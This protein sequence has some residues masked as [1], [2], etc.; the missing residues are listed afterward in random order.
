MAT[1][2]PM[3]TKDP[4]ATDSEDPKDL[5]VQKEQNV[6]FA[7]LA[8]K[9]NMGLFYIMFSIEWKPY[10]GNIANIVCR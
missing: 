7:V 10:M 3:A 2:H 5:K 8:S 9:C 4:M 6:I 1:K